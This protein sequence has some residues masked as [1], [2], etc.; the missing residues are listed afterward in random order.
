METDSITRR[1]H[2]ALNVRNQERSIAFYRDLF[3]TEPDKV[4][5]GF[6]R[7]VI[8]DPPLVL[9]LNEGEKVK[10]GSRVAH[11][12]VRVAGKSE[13]TQALERMKNAGYWV[14]EQRD[15]VCCHSRQDKFSV[16]DPDDNEWEIYELVDDMNGT[17]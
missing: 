5:D 10:T 6:A 8:C 13:V 12:G 2:I 14:R 4:R 9:S 7:F 16:R 3:D 11:L 17:D 1:L 15:I